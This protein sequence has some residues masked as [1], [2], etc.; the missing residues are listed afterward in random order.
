MSYGDFSAFTGGWRPHMCPSMQLVVG[1]VSWVVNRMSAW[2]LLLVARIVSLA[3]S[4][5]IFI[6][7]WLW[8]KLS[9]INHS[10]VC[11]L[12]PT[13]N[14]VIREFIV[15][16]I[17]MVEPTTPCLRGWDNLITW[18]PLPFG[19]KLWGKSIWQLVVGK[20]NLAVSCGECP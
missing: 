17:C 9:Q 13:S 15:A 20:V 6:L 2:Q 4:L 16:T 7:T 14:D 12:E 10:Q 1:N 3:V 8:N 5:N 11:F 18:P 19:S